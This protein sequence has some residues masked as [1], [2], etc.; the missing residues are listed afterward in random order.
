M[1]R[2]VNTLSEISSPMY[3]SF[4]LISRLKLM[5]PVK[6]GVFAG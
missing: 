1:G 4:M 6:P 3:L 5:P 2:L